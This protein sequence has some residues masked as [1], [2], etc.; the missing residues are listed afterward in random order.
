[1]PLR[2][3]V[4]ILATGIDISIIS[5]I[6]VIPVGF[7]SEYLLSSWDDNF[8]FSDCYILMLKMWCWAHEPIITIPL[9]LASPVFSASDN[10][11]IFSIPSITS[12]LL[13]F[14]QTYTIF[15]VTGSFME[16]ARENHGKA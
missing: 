3:K 12:S 11:G 13:C 5:V 9:L 14:L 2:Y 4:A 8:F 16:S 10:T 6:Y 1:M 7:F 15:F